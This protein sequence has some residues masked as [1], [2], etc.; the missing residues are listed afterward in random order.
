MS[1]VCL[2]MNTASYFDGSLVS[3]VHVNLGIKESLSLGQTERQTKAF[4][5]LLTTAKPQLNAVQVPRTHQCVNVWCDQC[6]AVVRYTYITVKS[7]I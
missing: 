6:K 1:Y 7:L 4:I 2:H 3:M 5:Q